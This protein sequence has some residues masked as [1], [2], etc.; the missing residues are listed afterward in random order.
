MITNEYSS[1]FAAGNFT[2]LSTFFT[3]ALMQVPGL[4]FARKMKTCGI[5]VNFWIFD[6]KVSFAP[7]FL[8]QAQFGVGHGEE[9]TFMFGNPCW[10][11]CSVPPFRGTFTADDLFFVNEM[12][13]AWGSFVKGS[14]MWDYFPFIKLFSKA[15]TPLN[16]GIVSKNSHESFWRQFPWFFFDLGK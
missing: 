9:L 1:N 7:P 5:P 14:K 2:A 4:A 13:S 11:T 16:E 8:Q 15:G 3:D 10:L 12:Q 6:Y